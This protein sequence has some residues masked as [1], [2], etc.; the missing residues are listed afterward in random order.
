MNILGF[1][2]LGWRQ[3]FLILGPRAP[4][5][6]CD[7]PSAK[8]WHEPLTELFT[9]NLNTLFRSSLTEKFLQLLNCTTYASHKFLR[10]QL[11]S[12]ASN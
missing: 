4:R 8:Y 7:A 2:A 9:L 5:T 12:K 6:A 1:L 3:K 10:C 11:K